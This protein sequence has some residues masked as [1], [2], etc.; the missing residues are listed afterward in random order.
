MG[1]KHCIL[2][3]WNMTYKNICKS[4]K[5]LK[6]EKIVVL[7]WQTIIII[8]PKRLNDWTPLIIQ[9]NFFWPKFDHQIS[10]PIDNQKTYFS[11]NTTHIWS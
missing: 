7:L 9:K 6:I 5:Y 4:R 2:V 11:I 1:E 8:C 10:F 3:Q